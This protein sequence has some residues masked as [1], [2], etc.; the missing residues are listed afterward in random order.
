MALVPRVSGK[1][2]RLLGNTASGKSAVAD[3]G[4]CDANTTMEHSI[5]IDVFIDRLT[6]LQASPEVQL[7]DI[8]KGVDSIR[9]R[10][11]SEY[12]YKCADI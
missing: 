5:P 4:V 2:Y 11:H 10:L 1:S 3:S 7:D 8:A 6:N 12:Q 9:F